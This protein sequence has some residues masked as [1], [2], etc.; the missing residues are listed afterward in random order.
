M[1]EMGAGEFSFLGSFDELHL[2]FKI[3]ILV[4]K[5]GG[6][7]MTPPP[8]PPVPK[9]LKMDPKITF[10]KRKLM[11]LHVVGIRHTCPSNQRFK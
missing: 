10:T 6:G 8:G 5:W 7:G 1:A 2:F 9:A 11:S 3:F 4:K